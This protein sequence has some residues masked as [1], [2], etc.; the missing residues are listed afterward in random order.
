MLRLNFT[1]FPELS[2]E[3]LLLRQLIHDDEIEMMKLRSDDSVNKFIIRPKTISREEVKKHIEKL[4][5]G[6]SND[7]LIFWA[8]TFKNLNKLIGTICLFNIDKEKSIGEIGFELF[9][10]NQGIGLMN[11]ALKKVL[12]YGLNVMKIKSFEG[13]ANINNVRSIKLMEKYNFKRADDM[14]K[15]ESERDKEFKNM[16]IYRVSSDQLTIKN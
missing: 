7:E 3:R 16:V 5:K 1:P 4:N 15:K 2:T 14:E 13:F 6:I 10:E 8:I 12:E 11:E 9:P